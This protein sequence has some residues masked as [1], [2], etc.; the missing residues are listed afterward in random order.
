MDWPH[1][2]PKGF[3]NWFTQQGGEVYNRQKQAVFKAQNDGLYE[4]V[5]D[6]PMFRVKTP[7]QGAIQLLKRHRDMMF[8]S[9]SDDKPISI[10][11]ATLAAK[12]YNLEGDLASALYAILFS[13]DR[14]IEDRD[15]I[16]WVQ[17]P[18]DP[19]ENF[20][21]KWEAHPV[22]EKTF[23][24]WLEQA[25]DD[26]EAIAGATSGTSL[27]Q[28]L[29]DRLGAGYSTAVREAVDPELLGKSLPSNM[30]FD[31][32]PVPE[33]VRDAPHKKPASWAKHPTVVG[34]VKIVEALVG[35]SR[36]RSAKF[37]S[38]D[39]SLPKNCNLRFRAKT[40]VP[41]PYSVFWQTLNTGPEAAAKGPE[42]LRG[43]IDTVRTEAG[44]LIRKESTSYTGS[45]SIE[46]FIVKD[47]YLV[48]RSGEFVVNIA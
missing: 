9:R 36:W 12:S 41:K 45:H 1:S 17:N 11:I 35:K 2:N 34:E 23:Y 38:G 27:P 5:D 6:V 40:S 14:H 30:P 18:T 32:R 15:G 31:V 4:S 33:I 16:A 46:C 48:A 47:G 21:D 29:G 43:G 24:E 19:L 44:G 37:R 10:I 13:M 25:R 7:L 28:D 42:G 22:L 3:A 20:A 8:E 26:F 39:A